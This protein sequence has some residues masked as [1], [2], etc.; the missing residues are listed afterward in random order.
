[1]FQLNRVREF[2]LRLRLSQQ[3]LAVKSNVSPSEVVLIEKYHHLPSKEVRQKLTSGL[4]VSE[5]MLWPGL[6]EVAS[7]SHD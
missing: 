1:M 7:D 6:Q 3:E 4:G 5:A 2:R